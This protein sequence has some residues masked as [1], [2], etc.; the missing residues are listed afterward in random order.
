M[1]AQEKSQNIRSNKYSDGA[2]ENR[3]SNGHST[4]G[5]RKNLHYQYIEDGNAA[6]IRSYETREAD[7]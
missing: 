6:I 5:R 2:K 4:E 1:S 3:N 7:D